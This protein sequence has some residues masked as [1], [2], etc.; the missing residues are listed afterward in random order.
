MEKLTERNSVQRAERVTY[1]VKSILLMFELNKVSLSTI[2][3]NKGEF[4]EL[5]ELGLFYK[6]NAF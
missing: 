1:D 3:K 5:I 4:A 6:Y 2:I